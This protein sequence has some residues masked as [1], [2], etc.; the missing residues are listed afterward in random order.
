MIINLN[1]S[2]F[3]A[4]KINIDATEV[5]TNDTSR[6]GFTTRFWVGVG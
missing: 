1:K 4:L 5:Q 3:L 2:F 6:G